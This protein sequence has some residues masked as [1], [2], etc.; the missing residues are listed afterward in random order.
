M[1]LPFPIPAGDLPQLTGNSCTPP[2]TPAADAGNT[3]TCGA[4]G[5][6]PEEVGPGL[7]FRV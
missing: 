5:P 4:G 3:A 1:P 2:G 6:Y 7:G